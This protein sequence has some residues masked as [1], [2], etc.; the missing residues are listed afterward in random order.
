VTREPHA[1]P[2][3]I[4]PWWRGTS[5][6]RTFSRFERALG[7]QH[8]TKNKRVDPTLVDKTPGREGACR[9]ANHLQHMKK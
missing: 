2:H 3:D 7:T 6:A 5:T 8:L 9:K 1:T 4:N